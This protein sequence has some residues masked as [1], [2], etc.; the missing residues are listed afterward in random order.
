[1][2]KKKKVEGTGTLTD[3]QKD[4]IKT[5]VVRLGL[6]EKVKAD[7]N[8]GDTVSKYALK[9]AEW[10]YGRDNDGVSTLR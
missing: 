6:L 10:C 2:T 9:F 7:Y 3:N 8:R 4:F 5:K 1:M